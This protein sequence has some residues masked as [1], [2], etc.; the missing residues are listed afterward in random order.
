MTGAVVFKT[1]VPNSPPFED[2]QP[3]LGFIPSGEVF[4]LGSTANSMFAFSATDGSHIWSKPT[5]GSLYTKAQLTPQGGVVFGSCDFYVYHLN[6]TSGALFWKYK[7]ADYVYYPLV[8]QHFVFAGDRVGNLFA[9]DVYS[10]NLVWNQTTA[11]FAGSAPVAAGNAV[12]Y[13]DQMGYVWSFAV[14]DGSTNWGT[15]IQ[16]KQESNDGIYAPPALGN[17]HVF[18]GTY[19]GNLAAIDIAN[20]TIAWKKHLSIGGLSIGAPALADGALY[21]GT[22]DGVVASYLTGL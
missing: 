9:I 20:G 12:I 13:G 17:T 19:Y 7:M 6:A 18:Y 4:F 1:H 10:G 3:T 16:D 15:G 21:F 22:T 2:S 5:A 11:G 8:Y 14:K